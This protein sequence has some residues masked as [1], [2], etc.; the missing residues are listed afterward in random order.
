MS[1]GE[2][3]GHLDAQIAARYHHAIR[4]FKNL[5]QLLQS[6]RL[7]K[8]GNHR[9]CGAMTLNNFFNQ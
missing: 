7:F 5:L 1:I 2:S 9:N 8:F 6:L 3:G 4:R